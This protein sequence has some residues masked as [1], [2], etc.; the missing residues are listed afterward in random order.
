M[1]TLILTD[2]TDFQTL[3]LDDYLPEQ[4]GSAVS[5]ELYYRPESDPDAQPVFIGNVKADTIFSLPFEPRD[6]RSLRFFL[7]GHGTDGRPEITDLKEANQ[8]VFEPTQADSGVIYED[9][10]VTVGLNYVQLQYEPWQVQYVFK[11][12][13]QLP[14]NDYSV[15]GST[16]VFDVSFKNGDF[17]SVSY[18]V[19]V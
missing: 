2:R 13:D 6:G 4:Q 7:V 19:L 16:V 3:V 10:P 15:I 9:P 1:A 14:S 11:N 12:G 5:G 8:K 17:V 18:L